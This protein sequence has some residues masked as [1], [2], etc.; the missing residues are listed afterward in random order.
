MCTVTLASQP[1]SP[2]GFV[3]TSNR[4]EAISRHA[5]LPEYEKYHSRNLY[6][7]KDAQAG[8]TW[9]GVSDLQRCLCLMNGAFEPHI[10]KAGYRKSR[11]IV[12]KDILAETGKLSEVLEH[13]DLKGIEAFTLVAVDWSNGLQFIE[14]VWD[15]NKKHL[16]KLSLK[17]H[18]WSSSPLYDQNMKKSRR[19]WFQQFR[20]THELHAD[21]L[22]DFHLNTEKDNTE[23]GLII[24]RGFLKTQSVSQIISSDQGIRFWFRDL[25]SGKEQEER[26]QFK[27]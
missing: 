23:Y 6:F 1:D 9:I 25:Q 20:E 16:Q 7:P 18:I 13:Y 27:A 26:L 2:N 17:P 3:L 19:Q 10:R 21:M 4:D 5:L 8:G 11:G 15:E 24:D 22:R 12:V 14:L